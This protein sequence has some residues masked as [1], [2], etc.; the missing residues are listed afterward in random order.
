MVSKTVFSGSVRFLQVV[1]ETGKVDAKADPKLSEA[2]L[3]KLFEWMVQSRAFDDKC[4]KLQRS[5]KL[6]T[7]IAVLGQEAQV[8]PTKLMKEVGYGKGYEMRDAES[9]LPE[10]LKKKKYLG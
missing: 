4:L 9:F 1:D 5:G 6:G 2:D 3:K 8:A 10:K 7:Y